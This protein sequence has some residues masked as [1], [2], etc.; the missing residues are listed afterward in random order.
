MLL[1]AATVPYTEGLAAPYYLDRASILAARSLRLP[2]T[3][4]SSTVLDACAAPGGKTLV[5]ASLLNEH[6]TILANELS[7]ERRRRLAAVLDKHLPEKL[8]NRVQVTGFDAAAAA[9]R[10]S[11][12]CR[13]AAVL[14]DAP[15]SSERHVLQN[16]TA[17]EKWTPSRPRFLASR[18]W[19]LLSAAFL[20]LKNGGSLVYATCSINM[21]E[22]DRVAGRL[23]QKYQKNKPKNGEI[24]ILDKPDFS[25]GEETEYGRIILPDMAEGAGPLYVAR[26]GKTAI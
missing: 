7:D 4:T 19:S 10:Q 20:L 22:N 15:C 14:L 23:L 25:E 24:C 17:L 3:D 21:E 2:N 12:R 18:Q 11:E 16:K 8:R 5:I 1:P 6:V 26:F 13:F 9:G